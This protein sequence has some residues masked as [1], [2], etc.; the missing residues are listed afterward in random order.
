[1]LEGK[2]AEHS[3]IASRSM[4]A[5]R[6]LEDALADSVRH[7]CTAICRGRHGGARAW[8]PASADGGKPPKMAAWDSCLPF[9]R[10]PWGFCGPGARRTPLCVGPLFPSLSDKGQ[11]QQNKEEVAFRYPGR[12]E[13]LRYSFTMEHVMVSAPCLPHSSCSISICVFEEKLNK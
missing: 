6:L 3:A 13:A 11:G 1:M 7:R 8:Q 10:L 9:W 12:R 5:T 4:T 2:R